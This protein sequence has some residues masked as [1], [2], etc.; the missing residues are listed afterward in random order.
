MLLLF[1]HPKWISFTL[2]TGP[3]GQRWAQQFLWLFLTFTRLSSSCRI[4]ILS[5]WIG[6][7][8]HLFLF[9]SSGCD[10]VSSTTQ[11][12]VSSSTLGTKQEAEWTVIAATT[13]QEEDPSRQEVQDRCGFLYYPCMHFIPCTYLK[14][15]QLKII[16]S[17]A[18]W[19]IRRTHT[20]PE[21]LEELNL[22]TASSWSF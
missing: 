13:S 5:N 7:P 20:S 11:A 4:L 17:A 18:T 6:A 9:Y 21:F 2:Y 10:C 3:P 22:S 16:F 1:H 14:R 8:L 15:Q 19:W 12:V